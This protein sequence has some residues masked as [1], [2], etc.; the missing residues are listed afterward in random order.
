MRVGVPKEIKTHEY[1]VG[2]TP[3]GVRQLVAAGHQVLVEKGAGLGSD[4]ADQLYQ[5]AG[6]ELV[7]RA[8][9]VFARAE[10]IVK[11]KEPLAAEFELLQPGHL[12]FT[13][14]HLA[15]AP[16]LTRVLL[17]KK[18]TAIAYETIERADGLLPLLQP[19]SEIAGRMAV[20]VGAR[21]LEKEHG[22]RGVLLS[23]APGVRQ[24]RVAILG[25]G[26]VG[27]N[28]LRIAVGMGAEVT[29]LDID[30]LRLAQLDEQYG[31]RIH[32]LIS[33]AH[34]VEAVVRRCDL[35]IGAV[36][37]PGGKAPMLVSRELIGEMN[38]GAVIVDVAIDQ[39]GCVETIHVTTHEH[40]VYAVDGVIHY[41]VANMPGAVSRTST[42]AL[43]N[44]TLPYVE[45]L[46]AAGFEAAVA[47]D[48][49]F[50]RGINTWDG[51]LCNQP[52]AEALGLAFSPY[53]QA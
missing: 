37:L 3:A 44:S 33:N 11:V 9:E 36:L 2:M 15:A 40:P 13:Y 10:L 29:I 23:G 17:K 21:Y 47:G 35:L 4:L 24:G 16:E 53:P 52:V 38:E 48:P 6:A 49:A 8:A 31:N 18:I 27:R 41:G 43:T 30:P 12:L 14:L 39:G 34:N 32:T 7:G 42:F 5:K 46:A 28:A 25:A 51:K 22:G 20:Q 26:T 50:A 45:K 1:R 19:M